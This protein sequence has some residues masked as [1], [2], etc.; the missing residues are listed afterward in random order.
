MRLECVV[1]AID[2]NGDQFCIIFTRRQNLELQGSRFIP[3]ARAAV[4]PCDPP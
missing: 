2:L 4:R 3:R 1:V